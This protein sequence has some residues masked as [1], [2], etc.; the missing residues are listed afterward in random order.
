MPG[1]PD[2]QGRPP[3]AFPVQWAF[4]ETPILLTFEGGTLVPSGGTPER[5][6]SLPGCRLDPR[7]GSYR[8]E[9]RCYRAIVEHVL[10]NRWPYE[11]KARGYDKTPWP[12]KQRREP[13][14]HQTEAVDAWWKNGGRG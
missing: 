9:A 8:A 7:T 10:R 12:L 5:L 4:M 6:A 14:A 13:F 1:R 2:C 11:D 3:G